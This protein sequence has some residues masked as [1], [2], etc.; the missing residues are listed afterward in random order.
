MSYLYRDI[1]Q[2]VLFLFSQALKFPILLPIQ[3]QYNRGE[4]DG[5]FGEVTL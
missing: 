1:M 4:V 3:L 5:E 2:M